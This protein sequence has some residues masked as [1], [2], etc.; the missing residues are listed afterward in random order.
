MRLARSRNRNLRIAGNLSSERVSKREVFDLFHRFGRLAQISLKSAYGFV[1]YHNV[2]EAQVA[3]RNAEGVELGGRKIRKSLRRPRRPRCLLTHYFFADL[4]VSRTQ[5]RKDDRDRSPAGERKNSN[6]AGR[7]DRYDGREQGRRNRDEF[8]PPRS[9]SPRRQESRGSRDMHGRD[10]EFRG[11]ADRRERPRSRSP[12]NRFD[13][14]DDNHI[15]RRRSPSPRRAVSTNGANEFDAPRRYGSAVPDVQFVAAPDLQPEFLEWIRRA[16]NE[17]NLRTDVF[18]VSPRYH[19]EEFIQRQIIEGVVGIV[20]LDYRAQ[21]T[22]KISIQVFNRS[23][24]PS[25]RFDRYEDV[26]PSIAAE[27]VFREKNKGVYPPGTSQLSQQPPPTQTYQPNGYPGYANYYPPHAPGAGYNYQAAQPSAVHGQP[28]TP[29]QSTPDLANVLGQLL[30]AATGG[31]NSTQ[32]DINVLLGSLQTGVAPAVG[33]SG[34]AYASSEGVGYGTA[35]PPHASLYGSFNP[36]LNGAG[37]G[38]A[39]PT[40]R[41]LMEQLTHFRQ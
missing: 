28:P 8:R 2:D 32:I 12:H 7:G 22:A 15:Y 34:Q 3:M 25:V 23:G 29:V 26:D 36:G 31:Q 37:G 17:R 35:P 14:P 13:R 4:E 19:R 11:S 21:S 16:F 39:N 38:D 33:G 9:P 6:R 27:L 1:Q 18:F 30:P 20:D 24:G 5:K 10:R 41:A 40:V